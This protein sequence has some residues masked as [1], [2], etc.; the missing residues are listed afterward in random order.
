MAILVATA[1]I[2]DNTHLAYRDPFERCS[3]AAEL[4]ASISRQGI[5]QPLTVFQ[6]FPQEKWHVVHGFRRL[7]ALRRLGITQAPV[8]PI[9]HPE[10]IS[11]AFLEVLELHVGQP[12]NLREKCRA[13]TIA[14]ACAMPLNLMVKRLL[15][16]LGLPAQKHIFEQYKL[17]EQLPR[18]LFDILADRDFSL[19][20]CLPFTQLSAEEGQKLAS[21]I[22]AS[23]L[24]GKQIEEL[25]TAAR[26]IA[27]RESC[28]L[29]QILDELTANADSSGLMSC[30]T[31]RR[32]PEAFRRR[33]KINELSHDWASKWMSIRFD[34]NFN[35]SGCELVLAIDDEN[36]WEQNFEQTISYLNSPDFRR[37]IKQILALL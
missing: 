25:F 34:Q 8:T 27:A 7:A 22:R 32:Y 23:D 13:L 36:Q 37:Q 12:I 19:R 15:P 29:G 6:T 24:T 10:K 5:L 14:Q 18:E 33:Q 11:E 21:L 26:E 1:D 4:C 28:S 9:D 2:A 3:F 17:L 35:R 30:L 16:A 20:R 31:Q